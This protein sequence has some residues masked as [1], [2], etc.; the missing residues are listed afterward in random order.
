MGL[1]LLFLIL[2]QGSPSPEQKALDYFRNNIYLDPDIYKNP[3]K[4]DDPD[5]LYLDTFM[6][7]KFIGERFLDNF[8][9][10]VK[11]TADQYPQNNSYP[12][13]LEFRLDGK[14]LF[15]R[16]FR[17]ADEINRKMNE[18]SA[19]SGKRLDIEHPFKTAESNYDPTI[20]NWIYVEVSGAVFTGYEYYAEIRL[21]TNFHGPFTY[22][23]SFGYQFIFDTDLN[24]VDW[25]TVY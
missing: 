8:T 21:Y 3:Y 13:S 2:F 10:F 15:D 22:N 6:P 18:G 20:D 7:D 17:I 23:D 1:V 19:H 16:K 4:P 12:G 14:E 5:C 24:L 25:T 11:S 9:I